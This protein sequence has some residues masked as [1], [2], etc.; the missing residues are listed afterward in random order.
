MSKRI[1][2]VLLALIML[3]GLIPAG[4]YTFAEDGKMVIEAAKNGIV[5]GKYYVDGVLMKSVGI[6]KLG[7]DYYY[8]TDSGKV[9]VGKITVAAS[10]TNGLISAGVYTF[11]ED[12]KMIVS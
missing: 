9:Y 8:I 2:C 11:A 7:N 12:G 6:V 4:V 1:V 5:D 3:V 10:K